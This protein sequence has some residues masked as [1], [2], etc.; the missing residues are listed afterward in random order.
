VSAAGGALYALDCRA[1]TRD[2]GRLVDHLGRE[3]LDALQYDQL[4]GRWVVVSARLDAHLAAAGRALLPALERAGGEGE[5]GARLAAQQGALRDRAAAV[6]TAFVEGAA[7]GHATAGA[8][9]VWAGLSALA[10][11][12]GAH[13]SEEQA[14]AAALP[15]VTDALGAALRPD[16]EEEADYWPW[17]LDGAAPDEVAAALAVGPRRV[18]RRY[19]RRWRPAYEAV[20]GPIWA[21]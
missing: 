16:K 21:G 5:P 10:R 6:E 8:V 13:L 11:E 19:P 2:V 3:H 9:E 7:P 15:G 20:V 18:R 4:A 1:L 17:V 14:A 12:V